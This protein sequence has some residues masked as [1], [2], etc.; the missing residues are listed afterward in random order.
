[1]MSRVARRTAVGCIRLYQQHISARRL[2]R[3]VFEISCS[4]Y[5]ILAIHKFGLL[6]ACPAILRR[7]HR[8][9]SQ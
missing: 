1:M 5:A 7:L 2:P 8:C 6:R 9:R 3:C 4:E